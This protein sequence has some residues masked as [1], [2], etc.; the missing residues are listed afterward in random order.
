M[1][2]TTLVQLAKV[3][4]SG[5]ATNQLH[6]RPGGGGSA[7]KKMRLQH[8]PVP[9]QHKDVGKALAQQME[10]G[11][12]GPMMRASRERFLDI[13]RCDLQ[14]SCSRAY[15]PGRYAREQLARLERA[16]RA[17]SQLPLF[18]KRSQYAL[19]EG[20]TSDF[21][22][23]RGLCQPGARHALR[24]TPRDEPYPRHGLPDAPGKPHVT[25]TLAL[26]LD[27]ARDP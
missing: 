12:T 14:A 20:Q 16:E 24:A 8:G 7:K 22:S 17:S 25:L 2:E 4:S 27:P 11:L 26:P 6:R 9:Q 5:L 23:L 10:D 13:T 19:P 1:P 18:R 15:H 3:L 21:V